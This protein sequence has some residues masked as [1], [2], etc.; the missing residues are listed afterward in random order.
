MTTPGPSRGVKS[1]LGA[2][3]RSVEAIA[4][5]VRRPAIIHQPEVGTPPRGVFWGPGGRGE[6]TD[7]AETKRCKQTICRKMASTPSPSSRFGYSD[8]SR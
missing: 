4:A 8:P 1:I 7:G 3:L 6:C 2:G 5:F